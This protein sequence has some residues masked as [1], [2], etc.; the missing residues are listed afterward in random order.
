V[1]VRGWPDLE[2]GHAR[3]C[4]QDLCGHEKAREEEAT[5][6]KAKGM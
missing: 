3:T 2:E 4:E 5:I 1:L 6:V